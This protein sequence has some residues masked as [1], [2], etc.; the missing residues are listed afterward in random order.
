M[1]KIAVLLLS[2]LLGFPAC[3]EGAKKADA[4]ETTHED[5]SKCT[6][7]KAEK[8]EKTVVA[9]AKIKAGKEGDFTDAAKKL[10]EAT[11]QEPGNVYYMVYQS[12]VD[13]SEFIFYEIYEDDDAFGAHAGSEHF[14]TFANTIPP[15]LDGD[16]IITEY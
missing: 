4:S 11:R 15:M 7:D 5:C 13:P 3:N 1:K 9:R 8:K 12:P 2:A 16:L 10:V 6:S 14:S